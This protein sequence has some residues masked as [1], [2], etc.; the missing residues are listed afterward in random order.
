VAE[1]LRDYHLAKHTRMKQKLA[2][3]ELEINQSINKSINYNALVASDVN[4]DWTCKDK[5][6]DK[7]K[8]FTFSAYKDL[9]GLYFLQLISTCS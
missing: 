3:V 9:Q 5:D 7:D 2:G 4:K 8:D 6:K 1:K